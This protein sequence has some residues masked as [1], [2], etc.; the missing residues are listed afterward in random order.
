MVA[1]FSRRSSVGALAIGLVLWAVS[2]CGSFD[3]VK[4]RRFKLLPREH[5]VTLD[6]EGVHWHVYDDQHSLKSACTNAVGGNH[7]SGECSTLTKPRFPWDGEKCP[8]NPEQLKDGDPA[9]TGPHEPICVYGVISRVLEC[10][11]ETSPVRCYNADPDGDVS[12]MWG[13]GVGL[14]F[15][16]DGNTAWNPTGHGI[17]PIK[18]VAFDL[19]DLLAS[20]GASGLALRVEFPIVLEADTRVPF[21]KRPLMRDDGRVI[22]TDGKLLG[23]CPTP[24][25]FPPA[26]DDPLQNAVLADL[27]EPGQTVTSNQHPFGHPFWQ[28]PQTGIPKPEWNPS[29]VSRGHN[30]FLWKDVKAPPQTKDENNY[31]F[32]R[33]VDSDLTL[34]LT[35]DELEQYDLL[36]I[37]FHVVHT[38]NNMKSDIPF[39]FCIENLAFLLDE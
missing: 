29:P 5:D 3:P 6:M 25:R 9:F 39:A 18:G 15:S 19:V 13:A 32:P 20:S 21:G 22:G 17:G 11:E 16:R 4:E 36:G 26:G 31:D 10:T 2:A 1:V 33:Y 14:Q 8:P 35:P 34:E 27:V 24:T 37:E 7:D 23:A 30:E 28:L 38:K 12:N